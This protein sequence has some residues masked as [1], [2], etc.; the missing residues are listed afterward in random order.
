MNDPYD[1]GVLVGCGSVARV[2]WMSDAAEGMP[3]ET[4]AVSL[5]PSPSPSL[6]TPITIS[7]RISAVRISCCNGQDPS[8]CCTSTPVRRTVLVECRWCS[9]VDDF[10]SRIP[11]S[12]DFPCRFEASMMLFD[13]LRVIRKPRREHDTLDG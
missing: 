3:D 7:T 5:G 2:P 6:S 11:R 13:G 10:C 1:D 8:W 9:I 4:A 12:V